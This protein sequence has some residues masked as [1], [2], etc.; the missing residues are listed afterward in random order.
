MA[1][2]SSD[3]TTSGQMIWLLIAGLL[4][5][6]YHQI[7]VLLWSCAVQGYAVIVLEVKGS[8]FSMQ[9]F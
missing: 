6:D 3:F 9:V 4:M 5:G 2:A 7:I 8:L 1:I